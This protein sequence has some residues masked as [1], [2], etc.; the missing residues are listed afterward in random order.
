M[1]FQNRKRDNAYTGKQWEANKRHWRTL[2]KPCARCGGAIDYDAPYHVTV[3]GKRTIN[4][5]ALVVGHIVGKA[6]AR[7]KG[8]TEE[9][10]NALANTQPECAGCSIK[11]GAQRGR[12]GR[13]MKHNTL[14]RI[15]D[16]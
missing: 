11:S 5:R 8:W 9:Q 12:K 3:R 15:T 2:R 7:A 13:D 10:T 1:A 6:D 14:V 16:W 4:K